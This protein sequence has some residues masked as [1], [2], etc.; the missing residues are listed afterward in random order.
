MMN[1]MTTSDHARWPGSR[2]RRLGPTTTP[3]IHKLYTNN[4][5]YDGASAASNQPA[6]QPLQHNLPSTSPSSDGASID[7]LVLK[8][9]QFL[10]LEP[11]EPTVLFRQ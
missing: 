6:E 8:Y 1:M 4:D 3:T 5:C 9:L 2:A 7:E 10:N 11:F